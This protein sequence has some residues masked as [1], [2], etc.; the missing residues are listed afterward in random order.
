[1]TSQQLLLLTDDEILKHLAEQAKALRK[2]KKMTQ[3]EFANKAGISYGTYIKFESKG[4]ISLKGFLTVLRYLGRLKNI[5]LLLEK[6]SIQ[7][8][9]IKAY[10]SE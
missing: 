6:E 1:M 9:G 3:K 5:S 8:L 7:D 4:I 2:Q 10:M